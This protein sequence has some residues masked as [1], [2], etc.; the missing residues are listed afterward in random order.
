MAQKEIEKGLDG[1]VID[2][3]ELSR[4]F[5][6][7]G[8]LLFRGYDIEDIAHNG[9]FEETLYLMWHG[10]LPTEEEYREFSE[11]LASKR[12]VPE[13]IVEGVLRTS[14]DF[15]QHPMDA[16]QAAVSTLSGTDD[17]LDADFE[18]ESDTVID[19]GS[20]IAAKLPTITA[21]YKRIREGLDPIEPRSDLS[22]AANFLYMLHGEEPPEAFVDAMDTALQIH[23]D[24]GANASTFT[25]RVISSTLANPYV[26]VA[27]GIGAL[28]GPLHGGAN[29]DV[30]D[31]LSQY[32]ESEE[33][34]ETWV[35]N[36]L[37]AGN[38]IAGWGHRVYNVK[39]PRAYILQEHAQSILDADHG[40]PTWYER[41]R[42][43]E[44]Y[45]TSEMNLG[46]KGIAPNVDYYSGTVYQQMDIPT[47]V[48]TNLFTMS[49]VGGWIGHIK[50]QYA[51]NRIIRP[52][53]RYVGETDREWVPR[54]DRS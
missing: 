2:E 27:G 23:M 45:L 26:A 10:E 46:E 53:V 43:L 15:D 8:R 51:D 21:A 38:V 44:E 11:S 14:A 31:M 36:W 50:E 17:S 4:V 52:R 30:L 32:E 25:T 49:R 29:Q 13:S 7:E 6:D 39:D 47:D 12:S 48:Y 28:S 19:I 16:L 33:D 22:H 1:V 54:E 42:E 35:E 34:L 3:S 9:D 20:S 41:A 18:N 24:H 40:D 5:G 37:D